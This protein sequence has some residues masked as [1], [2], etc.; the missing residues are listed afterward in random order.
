MRYPTQRKIQ[1]G[2]S[3]P[4]RLEDSGKWSGAAG[5]WSMPFIVSSLCCSFVFLSACAKVAD[6]RPPLDQQ[7]GT[8]QDLRVVQMAD[9]VRMIFSLPAGEIQWIEVYRQCERSS[10]AVGKI[11]LI[12]RLPCNQLSSGRK[13]GEFFFEYRPP[14]PGHSCRYALRFVNGQGRR[15]ELSNFAQHA[16]S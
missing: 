7:P 13:Q 12:V 2:V 1:S 10:S 4:Q 16:V 9:Q 3:S 8:V 5:R 11:E 14:K 15:S 6:P